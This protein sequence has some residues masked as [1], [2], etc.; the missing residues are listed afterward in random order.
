MLLVR[1][2]NTFLEARAL[3]TKQLYSQKWSVFLK[4][5]FCSLDLISCDVSYVL[6][7]LQEQLDKGRTPST[8]KVNVPAIAVN[9]SL[10]AGHSIG[11]T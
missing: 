8:P 2:S 6:T 1:L 9:H 5:L 11:M 3:S 10:N 7:F 4:W